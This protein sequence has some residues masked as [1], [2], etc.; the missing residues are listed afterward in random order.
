ML[1]NQK[2]T[3]KSL[4]GVEKSVSDKLLE[5]ASISSVA[6]YLNAK[7]YIL[8]DEVELTTE[9]IEA[10]SKSVNNFIN[11]THNK[12]ESISEDKINDSV[13]DETLTGNV[14]GDDE[15]KE[16]AKDDSTNKIDEEA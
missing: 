15:A 14:E 4:D 3:L 6:D 11:K 13:A 8:S 16:A 2:T 10:V 1:F 12:E 9:E 5:V 7:K